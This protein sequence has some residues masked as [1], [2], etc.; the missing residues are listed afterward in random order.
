MKTMTKKSEINSKLLKDEKEISF[1]NFRIGLE[2]NLYYYGSLFN[3]QIYQYF[4]TLKELKQ[5][6]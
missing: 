4:G 2:N 6:L 3:S 5:I 1:N